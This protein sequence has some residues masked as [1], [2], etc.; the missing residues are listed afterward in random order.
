MLAGNVRESAVA[1]YVTIGT[2]V[3]VLKVL[4]LGMLLHVFVATIGDARTP[5]R[6]TTCNNMS[7][8]TQ[9][10]DGTLRTLPSV[11]ATETL[12]PSTV[13]SCSIGIN[14]KLRSPGLLLLGCIDH[15]LLAGRT[16]KLYNVHRH[17]IGCASRVHG[18]AGY[19]IEVVV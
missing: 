9:I 15:F 8:Q 10:T 3:E 11:R 14:I 19:E 17:I 6:F 1:T 18:E 4:V 12:R 16:V 5:V 7:D 13:T 2:R